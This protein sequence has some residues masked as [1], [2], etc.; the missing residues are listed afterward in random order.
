MRNSECLDRASLQMFLVHA[1]VASDIH[2]GVCISKSISRPGS[3]HCC[4]KQYITSWLKSGS[5]AWCHFIGSRNFELCVPYLFSVWQ[6]SAFLF[7]SS[8]LAPQ[9][10]NWKNQ[11]LEPSICPF[12]LFLKSRLMNQLFPYSTRIS[13]YLNKQNP[14]FIQVGFCFPDQNKLEC[15][16]K[17]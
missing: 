15:A 16:Y 9:W 2:Q 17:P 7:W 10:V 13:S 3:F 4:K 5:V 1:S 12:D 8:V 14:A 11:F 6:A